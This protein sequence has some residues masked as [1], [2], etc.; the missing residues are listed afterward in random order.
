MNA[1]DL[2][3]S[4]AFYIFT[5]VQLLILIAMG[6]VIVSVERTQPVDDREIL[7]N[8]KFIDSSSN[9]LKQM[10]NG[11]SPSV[12]IIREIQFRGR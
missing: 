3:E 4:M 6:T 7:S 8:Q 2:V 12:L 1:M 10:A 5:M 9:N 11:H